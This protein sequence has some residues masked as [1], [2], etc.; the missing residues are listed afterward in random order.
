MS[1][2]FALR[3]CAAA[4]AEHLARQAAAAACLLLPLALLHAR[5]GAEILIGVIDVL[6][7]ARTVLARDGAWLRQPFAWAAGV[8][9]AWL[10]LCSALGTGGLLHG[11]LAVRLP[12]LALALGCWVLAGPPPASGKLRH[13]LWLVL[14][15]AFCWVGL[16]AWEQDLTGVN[17]FGQPRWGDGALTGPFAKPRAGPAF[18][19]LFFP[20]VVPAVAGLAARPGLR[21]RLA[22]A[23]LAVLAAATMVL[24]GQRMPVAL[25]LLGL[26]VAALLLPAL[27]LAALCAALAGA[28]LVAA[29]PWVSPA[30]SVKLLAQTSGQ[31]AHFAQSEYGLIFLRALAVA[32][33]HPWLGL[34]FDGFRRGCGSFQAVH[35]FDWLGIPAV[36]PNSGISACNL[37]PHNYYLEAVDNAGLPG[38][39]AFVALVS[40]ALL[41]LAQ[42][43]AR[44]RAALQAG[45]LVGGIVA[46]WPLASTSAFTS[47]PNGG[48]VFLLLGLG[49]AAA[50]GNN[51]APAP[52]RKFARRWTKE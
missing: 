21:P 7:L 26:A 44:G 41:R 33:L 9:W 36:N 20:V 2:T 37:H 35:E 14:A 19:L 40:C 42:G 1:I 17:L 52:F 22:G 6:F 38:L 18:I 23:G 48:W 34:G 27:R 49:F 45:L 15:A 10:S 29:L 11:L 25:M 28:A 13:W 12:V 39:L 43:A 46:L 30:A 5:A 4:R 47:M 16:Q 8:W 3:P 51:G 24:I 31:M 50:G 32:K